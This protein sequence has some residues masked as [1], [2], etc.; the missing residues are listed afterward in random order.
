LS[1]SIKSQV[2]YPEHPINFHDFENLYISSL[3]HFGQFLQTFS[4]TF[5]AF[6]HAF[7]RSF[8]S[9]QFQKLSSIISYFSFQVATSSKS[10]STSFVNLYSIIFAK[11]FS[12]KSVTVNATSVGHRYLL[13]TFSMYHLSIIVEIVG[14]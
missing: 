14:A 3:S 1:C 9:T 4:I 13:S 10:S 7:S 6:S 12:K 5:S 11:Y 8:F 2:G